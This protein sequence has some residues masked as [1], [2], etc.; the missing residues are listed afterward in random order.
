MGTDVSKKK[1]TLNRLPAEVSPDTS[2]KEEFQAYLRIVNSITEPKPWKQTPSK[3]I[4]KDIVSGS[5]EG[6]S[7]RQDDPPPQQ[8]PKNMPTP[9]VAYDPNAPATAEAKAKTEEICN[10]LHS[11]QSGIPR[12]KVKDLSSTGWGL[13]HKIFCEAFPSADQIKRH[14]FTKMGKRAIPSNCYR[15]G[16]IRYK[17]L[18]IRR[19]ET[20]NS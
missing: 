2:A 1:L 3:I 7:E 8:D 15:I 5:T 9:N 10:V 18:H 16:R 6:H 19:L 17:Y 20:N 13:V 11:R 12:Q 14:L 4:I